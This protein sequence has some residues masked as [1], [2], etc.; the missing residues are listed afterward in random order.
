MVQV[1]AQVA[2]SE[3]LPQ[4]QRY[5]ERNPE[6]LQCDETR[7]EQLCIHEQNKILLCE[8]MCD[9]RGKTDHLR[10]GEAGMPRHVMIS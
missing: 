4:A 5:Q 1:L 8:V 3:Y 2:G 10:D 7:A 6:S 9:E